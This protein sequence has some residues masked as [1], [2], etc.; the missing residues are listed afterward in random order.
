MEN[1]STCLFCAESFLETT[2]LPYSTIHLYFVHKEHYFANLLVSKYHDQVI[3][4]GFRYI[5]NCLREEFWIIKPETCGRCKGLPYDY[6]EV[7]LLP[8]VRANFDFLYAAIIIFTI[9]Y[10]NI[11]IKNIY[12][13]NNKKSI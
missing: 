4:N 3:R 13:K 9:Y 5:I 7:G 8:E 11:F 10:L 12:S 2:K 6:G 1:V